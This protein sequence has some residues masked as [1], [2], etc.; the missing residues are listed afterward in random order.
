[1]P[2][3]VKFFTDSGKNII[4]GNLSHQNNGFS[5]NPDECDWEK[6]EMLVR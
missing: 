4:A 5:K 1:V 2:I 6:S 3:E